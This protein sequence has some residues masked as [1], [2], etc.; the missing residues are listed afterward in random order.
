MMRLKVIGLLICLLMAGGVVRAQTPTPEP[1]DPSRDTAY[2]VGIGNAWYNAGDLTRAIAA[3]SCALERDPTSA[4]ALAR[5]GYARSAQGDDA[6]ALADL[7][8]ALALDPEYVDAYVH[9]GVL[10]VRQGIFALAQAD[11]D[12]A[13][14]LDPPNVVALHNRAVAYAA[15]FRYALALADLDAALAIAPDDP[16]LH[17]ALGAVYLGLAAESYGQFR[18]LA[19]DNIPVTGGAPQTLY[20]ALE[21]NALSGNFGEWLAFLRAVED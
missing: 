3:Y 14:R 9:R 17:A 1:C 15:E 16:E 13:L 10:Y 6:G 11:F 18:A 7:E 5:R 2:F 21:R 19:G 8:E 20:L 12:A 4:E